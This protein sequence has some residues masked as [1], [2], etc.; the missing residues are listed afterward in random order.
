[1]G[2]CA[3]RRGGRVRHAATAARRAPTGRSA[4]AGARRAPSGRSALSSGRPR[5]WLCGGLARGGPLSAAP[6]PGCCGGMRP[7]PTAAAVLATGTTDKKSRHSRPGRLPAH[8]RERDTVAPL[9]VHATPARGTISRPAYAHALWLR[10]RPRPCPLPAPLPACNRSMRTPPATAVGCSRA[11]AHRP[12]HATVRCAATP[13]RRAARGGAP[14]LPTRRSAA[15]GGRAEGPAAGVQA[16]L[17][18]PQTDVWPTR[19]RAAAVTVRP[20]HGAVGGPRP[21]RG[22][23]AVG[24]SG[25]RPRWLRRGVPAAPT[26]RASAP[27]GAARVPRGHLGKRPSD[28][29]PSTPEPQMSTWRARPRCAADAAVLRKGTFG[30]ALGLAGIPQTPTAVPPRRA[31]HGTTCRSRHE[32]RPRGP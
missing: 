31:T 14:P 15:G 26:R 11:V 29:C 18:A 25:G 7:P 3:R 20:A 28:G 22:T 6:T 1:M 27:R 21:W 8:T 30:C 23:A 16:A 2:G 24:A 19:H 10:W 5:G 12:H 13:W 32:A 17:L 9:L 4:L